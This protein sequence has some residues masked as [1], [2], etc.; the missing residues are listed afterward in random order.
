MKFK[1]STTHFQLPL[2]HPFTI[3]RHTINVQDA[4]IVSISDGITTGF[5]EATVNA[6]YGTTIEDLKSSIENVKTEILTQMGKHPEVLWQHIEPNL[7]HNYFAL[8]AIDCAYWDYF[9]RKNQ[10]T[11]RSYWI[12][13][14]RREPK[15][16]Y[17]IGIDG[18]SVMIEKI[19]QKPWP[20][21]KI[22]LGVG[23]DLEI[24]RQLR[25]VTNAVFRVDA[26]CAWEVEEAIQN[27]KTLKE[28]G[29]EF[30][31]QPLRGDNWEG[32]KI[33]R[34]KGALP[35]IADESCQKVEDIQKCAEFFDGINIKLMK[36]GGIT[37]ALKMI[38]KARELNLKIMAGCMTESSIGISNLVQ[39]APLL[40]YIDADGAMLLATDIASGAQ[41]QNGEIIFPEGYGSGSELL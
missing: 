35:I 11:L 13:K 7:K 25:Q 34:E 22:K 21:Y 31:E 16:N 18:I 5:G 9:A 37:P 36:C 38:Q 32:M 17:T 26:N 33:L 10:R 12:T 29:V 2:K 24:M 40:D 27:S 4:L 19:K 1:L 41:F 20:I 28:L 23:N 39:L 6:Y 3:S 14:E 8:S 15:T 30:I